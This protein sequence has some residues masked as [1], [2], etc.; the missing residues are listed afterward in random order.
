MNEPLKIATTTARVPM[1]AGPLAAQDPAHALDGDELAE[2]L[3]SLRVVTYNH[4]DVIYRE[5][6]N[7]PSI[8]LVISGLVKLFTHVTDDRIRI[9]R[10]LSAGDFLG[11]DALFEGGHR[12]TA[13]AL[14]EVSLYRIPVAMLRG[15]KGRDPAFYC[16]LLECWYVHLA[17]ADTWI[18][19]FSTGPIRPRVARLLKFLSQREPGSGTPRV[20]LLTCEEMAEVLGVTPESASRSLAEFKRDGLLRR[21]SRP[22]PDLFFCDLDGLESVAQGQA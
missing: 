20:R 3:G 14:G 5:C 11:L 22:D 17:Y 7:A 10:L 6:R 8:H 1:I 21:A 9:V 2:H 18:T 16:R 19:E 4:R 12:Q 15:L 13:M